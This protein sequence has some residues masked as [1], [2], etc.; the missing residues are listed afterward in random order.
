MMKTINI[1]GVKFIIM[2]LLILLYVISGTQACFW[3]SRLNKADCQ[4]FERNDD[5]CYDEIHHGRLQ[6]TEMTADLYKV[7]NV[8]TFEQ[9]RVYIH[10]FRA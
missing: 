8:I 2:N 5:A 1:I 7:C 10:L 9:W 3:R 4:D 6:A